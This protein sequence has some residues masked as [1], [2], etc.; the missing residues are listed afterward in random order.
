MLISG[1]VRKAQHTMIDENRNKLG[2]SSGKNDIK[3]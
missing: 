2:P 1:F 3:E